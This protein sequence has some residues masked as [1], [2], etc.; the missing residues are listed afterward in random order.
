MPKPMPKPTRPAPSV[1]HGG[2]PRP[3]PIILAP[4]TSS[5]QQPGV[6][7][8]P[9]VWEPG[10][11]DAARNQAVECLEK[12]GMCL[13]LPRPAANTYASVRIPVVADR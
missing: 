2:R 9:Q 7:A 4:R 6:Y 10:V 12:L 5:L 13:S 8:E 11:A 3:P 1:R